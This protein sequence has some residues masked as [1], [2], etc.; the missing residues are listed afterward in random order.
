MPKTE[1]FDKHLD[2]YEEWFVANRFVY[3]SE[4]AAV[5]ALVP[6]EG[7]GVEIGVG[8]GLFA[9]PLGITTGVEPSDKM[10]AKARQRGIE[11]VKG[12]AEALPFGDAS[13]DYALMVT[14]ICFVDDVERSLC[15]V[16]RVLKKEGVF[17][18]AFVDKESPVGKVYLAM[19]EK[20]LFYR[21]AT[22]FS[23]QELL[24][25]LHKAGLEE[26]HIVQTVFGMLDEVKEV[27]PVKEGY[28][29]GSFVVIRAGKKIE[30]Q[31]LKNKD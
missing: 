19:K 5:R 6:Q 2:L 9:A 17:I 26:D 7:V 18:L 11:V 3:E 28:G 14:T 29:E 8:S 16:N 10:A 30:E 12:V 4:L 1:P 25:A 23:T 24:E 27:Q 13:F 15:E 31:G 22:F 21:P 20:S